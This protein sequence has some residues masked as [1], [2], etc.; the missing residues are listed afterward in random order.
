M[1]DSLRQ[2]ILIEARTFHILSGCIPIGK[3]ELKSAML[4]L[5]MFRKQK[6]GAKKNRYIYIY[7]VSF[8][9]KNVT[10]QKYFFLHERQRF[11]TLLEKTEIFATFLVN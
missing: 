2:N 3:E 1:F 7:I 5:M 10:F 11:L 9:Q 8:V 4:T 6:V